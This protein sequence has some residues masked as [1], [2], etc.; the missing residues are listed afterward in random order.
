[1]IYSKF[2]ELLLKYLLIVLK[3]K[4]LTNINLRYLLSL[5]RSNQALTCHRTI[6][7]RAKSV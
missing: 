6:L 2:K 5:K 1:M 4:Y 3:K 7:K